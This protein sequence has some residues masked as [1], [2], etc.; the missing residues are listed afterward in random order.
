MNKD[1]A[2]KALRAIEDR[3]IDSLYYLGLMYL[4]GNGTRFLFL[5]IFRFPF[6]F[7]TFPFLSLKYNVILLRCSEGLSQ[8]VGV[9]QHGGCFE[10]LGSACPPRPNAYQRMGYL[11]CFFKY[12][13][14]YIFSF[15]MFC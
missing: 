10:S 11:L 13:I 14:L 15:E 12:I 1:A 5:L 3:S 9:S 7:T 2:V 6:L 4:L 8:G